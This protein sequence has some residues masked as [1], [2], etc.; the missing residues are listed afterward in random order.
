MGTQEE[1]DRPEFDVFVDRCGI[2]RTSTHCGGRVVQWLRVRPTDP[3]SSWENLPVYTHANRPHFRR[4]WSCAA[5]MF[6]A[7]RSVAR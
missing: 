7:R 1:R 5:V 6:A 4:C 3:R 2:G